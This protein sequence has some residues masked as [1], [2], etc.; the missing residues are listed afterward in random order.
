M[1]KHEKINYIEFPSKDIEK[2]KTFFQSV[3]NWI[4]KDYWPD[5]IAFSN[6]WIDGWF[7]KTNN[8]STTN[9]WSCLVVFYSEDIYLTQSKI[10][11][12]WGKIIKNL[13]E[14]PWG[15][16]FHFS[17]TNDNEYAVWTDKQIKI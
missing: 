16:R 2:T 1:N 9:N 15:F 10:I 11:N 4:F 14:F 5:Y 13:F 7:F 8:F 3:F 12:A 17:D 6:E